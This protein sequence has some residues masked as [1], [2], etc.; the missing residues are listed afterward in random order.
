[1]NLTQALLSLLA[2]A[3]LCNCIP[4]LA[5]GLRGERFPTPFATPR[6]VGLSA[7][8]TNA[9]WGSANLFL[10][11][12]LFRQQGWVLFAAGFVAAAVYLARHF[13]RVRGG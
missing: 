10:G 2:G 1:V 6:G 13:G 7:P 3:L 5:A 9:L 8:V 11:L 12:L 4:H